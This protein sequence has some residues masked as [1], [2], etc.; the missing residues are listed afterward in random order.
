ANLQLSQ[1]LTPALIQY[2]LIQRLSDKIQVMILPPGQNFIL[3]TD[4]LKG[5]AR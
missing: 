2:S 4:L 5:A 1:S 3:G